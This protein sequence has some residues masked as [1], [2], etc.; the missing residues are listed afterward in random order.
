MYKFILYKLM[1]YDKIGWIKYLWTHTI[2]FYYF[3]F[4][5]NQWINVKSVCTRIC[6]CIITLKEKKREKEKH[7]SFCVIK[8]VEKEYKLT[9]KRIYKVCRGDKTKNWLKKPGW[10]RYVQD[11]YSN[12]ILRTLNNNSLSL[13]KITV[14]RVGVFQVTEKKNLS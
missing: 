9:S 12:G 1:W 8:N 4:S 10:E 2:Y 11:L 3:V 6:D 7:M 5:F 13:S 14:E